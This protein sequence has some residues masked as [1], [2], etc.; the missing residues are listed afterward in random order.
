MCR[1]AGCLLAVCGSYPSWCVF[2]MRMC[3]CECGASRGQDDNNDS[4]TR[5]T[6]GAAADGATLSRAEQQ[7]RCWRQRECVR[8]SETRQAEGW[9]ARTR[10]GVD[11]RWSRRSDGGDTHR[12]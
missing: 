8:D 2:C 6:H 10:R 5:L 9:A 3:R 11:V 12:H 4:S 1:C 7:G